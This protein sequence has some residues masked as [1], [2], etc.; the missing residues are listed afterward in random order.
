MFLENEPGVVGCDCNLSLWE[1]EE[2]ASLGYKDEETPSQKTN[3]KQTKPRKPFSGVRFYGVLKCPWIN[4]G[5][6]APG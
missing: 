5:S 1:A 6:R 3:N 4:G 2:E